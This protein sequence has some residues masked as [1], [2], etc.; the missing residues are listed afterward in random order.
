[1]KE[2]P[3]FDY[4]A[5]K[6]MW[7]ILAETGWKYKS[8][9]IEIMSK[10]GTKPPSAYECYACSAQ[11]QLTGKPWDCR[12]SCCPLDWGEEG[13]YTFPCEQTKDGVVNYGLY[14]L[15]AN[16]T[17]DEIELRK[18]LAAKIRDLPLSKNARDLY[19]I[20]E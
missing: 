8:Q 15:W 5:H 17:R 4:W 13:Q 10:Q 20:I 3:E 16:T 12:K 11:A 1:M 18:A 7:A 9:A 6:C 2:K 14:F 19:T